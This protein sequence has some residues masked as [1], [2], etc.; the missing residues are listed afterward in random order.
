M[1]KFLDDVTFVDRQGNER[2]IIDF[3]KLNN[4]SDGVSVGSIQSSS[5]EVNGEYSVAIGDRTNVAG[6]NSFILGRYY[7]REVEDTKKSNKTVKKRF[8][9][10]LRR[11]AGYY[12]LKYNKTDEEMQELPFPQGEAKEDREFGWGPTDADYDY[13]SNVSDSDVVKNGYVIADDSAVIGPSSV[14]WNNSFAAGVSNQIFGKYSASVGLMNIVAAQDAFVAGQNNVLEPSIDK[15]EI[16]SIK[17]NSSLTDEEKAEKLDVAAYVGGAMFGERNR[18]KGSRVFVTGGYSKAFGNDAVSIGLMNKIEDGDGSF[19]IGQYNNISNSINSRIYGDNNTISGGKNSIIIG[20]GNSIT[21]GA[22]ATYTN[23]IIGQYGQ[24]TD[25]RDVVVIG[26][27]ND[28]S[29]RKNALTIRKESSDQTTIEISAIPKIWE[30][31]HFYGNITLYGGYSLNNHGTTYLHDN[32]TINGRTSLNGYIDLNNNIWAKDTSECS[33][34]DTTV[35]DRLRIGEWPN[36]I[37]IINNGNS[38]SISRPI[39]DAV[40]LDSINFQNA[41]GDNTMSISMDNNSI[42][43]LKDGSSISMS[44]NDN[45]RA[46]LYIN[47]AIYMYGAAAEGSRLVANYI[48]S[49]EHEQTYIYDIYTR[50]ITGC[51]DSNGGLEITNVSKITDVNGNAVTF[52]M[53][54]YAS[55]NYVDDA[56][57]SVIGGIQRGAITANRAQYLYTQGD[58]IWTNIISSFVVTPGTYAIWVDDGTESFSNVGSKSC[59]QYMGIL[60]LNLTDSKTHISG[61][62]SFVI[63]Y[64]SSIYAVCSLG[65]T[66]SGYQWTV[67]VYNG[68][69]KVNNK[70]MYSAISRNA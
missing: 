64:T 16:D 40:I 44:P 47:G 51:K 8:V 66:I 67:D 6:N 65:Q 7:E 63:K 59:F 9:N 19:T 32:V 5:S 70:V 68:S 39:K 54:N 15:L 3:N 17:N 13:Y 22:N 42:I 18:A 12:Q 30:P 24:L 60:P 35:R 20:M 55:Q 23:I 53:S 33:F 26:V 56:C 25:G 61:K 11:V 58:A 37:D 14:Y 4:L 28:E 48:G 46:R 10:D 50:H 36:N 69:T 27:G 2:S 49:D 43:N 41:S 21:N 38:L 52:D 62:T 31:S 45:G 1:P 29:S 57:N 34:Y